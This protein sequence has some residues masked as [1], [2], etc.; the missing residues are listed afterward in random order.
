[1]RTPEP[2]ASAVCPAPLFLKL[3]IWIAF[4]VWVEHTERPLPALRLTIAMTNISLAQL[5]EFLGHVI[6]QRSQLTG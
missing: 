4:S 6:L 3:V 5:N 1:M 2:G